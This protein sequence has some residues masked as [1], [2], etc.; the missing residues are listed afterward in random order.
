M[1][2]ET[3]L[4]F[5]QLFLVLIFINALSAKTVHEFSISTNVIERGIPMHTNFPITS[6][7]ELSISNSNWPESPAGIIANFINGE[8]EL[9]SLDTNF[10]NQRTL[11]IMDTATPANNGRDVHDWDI[12]LNQF[13]NNFY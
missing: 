4:T 1:K 3:K 13:F 8:S 12:H 11:L 2:L 7:C 5:S 9:T 10:T 6:H